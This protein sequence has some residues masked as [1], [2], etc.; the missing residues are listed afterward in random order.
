MRIPL[1]LE[2][3]ITRIVKAYN[4]AKNLSE[5][6]ADLSQIGVNIAVSLV[7]GDQSAA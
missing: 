2:E 6:R 7:S 1:A 3:D 5:A 4:T